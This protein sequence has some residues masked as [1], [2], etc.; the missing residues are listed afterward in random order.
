MEFNTKYFWKFY[1]MSPNDSE[2]VLTIDSE[3]V[4]TVTLV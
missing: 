2:Y 4:L 1:Q 3:H